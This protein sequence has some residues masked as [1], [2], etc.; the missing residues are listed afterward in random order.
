MRVVLFKLL[1]V[2]SILLQLRGI[3][4]LK[5]S[6]AIILDLRITTWREDG[7][8]PCSL[9]TLDNGIQIQCQYL[10]NAM[11]V[12]YQDHATPTGNLTK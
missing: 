5:Q 2:S 11:I 3:H 8:F 7:L 6:L 4:V 9:I 1:V 12:V 10:H